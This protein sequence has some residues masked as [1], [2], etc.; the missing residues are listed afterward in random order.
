MTAE[1]RKRVDERLRS[2][3]SKLNS[4]N[5]YHSND[6]RDCR[7]EPCGVQ[8]EIWDVER[9]V[10]DWKQEPLQQI[11]KEDK[12]QKL[13][14]DY[15]LHLI[16]SHRDVL[17]RFVHIVERKITIDDYGDE[18]LSHLDNEI[19]VCINKLKSREGAARFGWKLEERLRSHLSDLFTKEHAQDKG[20]KVGG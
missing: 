17:D 14:D 16:S 8:F 3:A 7:H 11:E 2:L 12:A 19:A 1:Q 10:R 5:S 18:V 4:L 6:C 20:K 15:F 13:E 9:A